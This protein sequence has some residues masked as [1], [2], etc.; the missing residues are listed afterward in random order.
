M[1][2][3]LVTVKRLFARSQNRC[4]FTGCDFPI[5]EESDTVTGIICHINARSPGG[6]MP[7]DS[8]RKKG[9]PPQEARFACNRRMQQLI[10]ESCREGRKLGDGFYRLDLGAE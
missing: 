6:P 10:T 4:A 9:N 8:M 1:E 2:P 7:G 5:V 3:S